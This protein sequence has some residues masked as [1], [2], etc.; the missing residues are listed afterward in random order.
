MVSLEFNPG[1]EGTGTQRAFQNSTNAICHKST[2]KQRSYFNLY[3]YVALCF[4][5]VF[6]LFAVLSE[7][8]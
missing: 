7:T 2:L 8:E 6:V 1:S 3:F 4:V 5:F